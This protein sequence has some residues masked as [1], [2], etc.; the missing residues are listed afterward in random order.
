VLGAKKPER[1]PLFGYGGF[2]VM[3]GKMAG[4]TRLSSATMFQQNASAC[5]LLDFPNKLLLLLAP[6]LDEDSFWHLAETCRR[7]NLLLTPLLFTH[8]GVDVPPSFSGTLHSLCF[9]GDHLTLSR[10]VN[11]AIVFTSVNV[12]DCALDYS[13]GFGGAN[14]NGI[15]EVVTAVNSLANRLSHGWA[16][17]HRL[18]AGR[19]LHYNL[20]WEQQ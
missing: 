20:Q 7:M 3:A 12:I 1:L 18:K 2:V 14:L 17:E 6:E 11:H 16:P 5:S 13:L 4:Q 9:T 15:F 10:A 8:L 19:F